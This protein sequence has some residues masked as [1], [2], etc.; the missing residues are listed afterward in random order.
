MHELGVVFH[1]IDSIE[2]VAKEN[3]VSHV[4]K[5]VLEVGEVSA[6]VNDYL[7]DCWNWAVKKHPIMTDCKLE[8]RDIPAITFCEDCKQT[9]ETVKYG[10]TCPYCQSGH[11]YLVQGNEANIKEIEVE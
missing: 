10:K 2:E 7:E 9:Y 5:V 1:I 11:T 8:I 3:E 6:I 4:S